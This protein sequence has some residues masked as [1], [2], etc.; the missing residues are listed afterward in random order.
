ML[1]DNNYNGFEG[2]KEFLFIVIHPFVHT[3]CHALYQDLGDMEKDK[4]RS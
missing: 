1:E 4:D 3:K 2:Y